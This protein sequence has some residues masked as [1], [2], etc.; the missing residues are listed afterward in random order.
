MVWNFGNSAEI[1]LFL[2]SNGINASPRAATFADQ[3]TISKIYDITEATGKSL[4]ARAN[5]I[6]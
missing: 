6:D 5:K 1:V 3:K 4:I 2:R